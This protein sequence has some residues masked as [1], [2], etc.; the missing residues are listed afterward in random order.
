MKFTVARKQF[1][2][3]VSKVLP[4]ITKSNMKPV[5]GCTLINVSENSINISGTDIDLGINVA[6]D[7][8]PTIKEAG[9]VCVD[10][11]VL[12]KMVSAMDD[13]NVDVW[14][15]DGGGFMYLKCGSVQYN[16][17][18]IQGDE[19]PSFPTMPG[20][21]VHA[22]ARLMSALSTAIVAAPDQEMR[23]YN[24]PA[25]VLV[26][27]IE[28]D[29]E[30]VATDGH[31]MIHILIDVEWPFG[32]IRRMVIPKKFVSLLGKAPDQYKIA[33]DGNILALFGNVSMFCRLKDPEYFP[34]YK[35]A[36]NNAPSYSASFDKSMFSHA[37]RR[38][39]ITAD[40]YV[41]MRLVKDSIGLS[42]ENL[43]VGASSD[44][45]A[46]EYNGPEMAIGVNQ[47]YFQD[48]LSAMPDGKVDMHITDDE[49]VIWI[50][51]EGVAGI[52]MMM[53]MRL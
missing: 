52:F 3:A 7:G 42:S 48:F 2:D 20:N 14:A 41:A 22:D 9:S 12:H 35:D 21:G 11:Q 18:Y 29:T 34:E 30:V 47:Q 49:S 28:T 4:A 6:L 38:V 33:T 39:A 16:M 43:F 27:A 37:L 53:P 8:N 19:F 5:L 15:E 24:A 32:G 36:I 44:T 23:M 51:R 50:K 13:G 46:S 40:G 1:V 25:G 17:V 31:R 26:A 45:V 10:A